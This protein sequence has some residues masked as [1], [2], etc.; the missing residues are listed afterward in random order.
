MTSPVFAGI[1]GGGTKTVVVVVDAGGSELARVQTGT[2]NPA[3]IG[4]QRAGEVLRVAIGEAMAAVDAPARLASAWFGLAGCDRP[5]DQRA[6]RPHLD[7]LAGSVRLTNDG[8]LV[9]G[10]LPQATGVALVAGT[11]SIA[12]GRAPDGARCRAGGWG[13][14]MG[15]EGSGYALGCGLLRAFAAEVDGRGP[16]TAMT[17]ALMETW[18]LNEPF[19]AISHVYGPP[20]SKG[21]IAGLARIVVDAAAAGDVV[22][23]NLLEQA[24]VDLAQIAR[25]TGMRLGFR[26]CLPIALTGSLLVH[27]EPLR[28]S[29]L[30]RLG[31]DW[32]AIDARIVVDPALVAARFVAGTHAG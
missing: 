5:D 9:L 18:R 23:S 21:E 16:A 22:A 1:D 25:V 32:S 15:D 2:S 19:E 30:Q 7:P 13:A 11:G 8:E 27:V 4:H 3:V 20:M 24:A 31:N 17:V 6:L 26:G 12:F 10:A 14:I 28:A 29:V